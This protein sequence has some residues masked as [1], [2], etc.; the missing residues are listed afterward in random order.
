MG[1][2]F[3]K[4]TDLLGKLSKAKSIE[5]DLTKVDTKKELNVF[6]TGYDTIKKDAEINGANETELD[7]LE[8]AM[9]EELSAIMGA[10][11]AQKAGQKVENGKVVFDESED[12]LAEMVNILAQST[13]GT[14]GIDA[15]KLREYNKKSVDTA[16]WLVMDGLKDFGFDNEL[17][18]VMIEQTP[19]TIN[20]VSNAI[21]DGSARNISMQATAADEYAHD[22]KDMDILGYIRYQY[23]Q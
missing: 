8:G 3:N 9:K 16:P 15:K 19:D 14:D 17:I 18:D 1:I 5:G 20:Y 10:N 7:K 13:Q 22:T 2:D 12:I 6:M 23:Q 4:Y 11:F 21:K